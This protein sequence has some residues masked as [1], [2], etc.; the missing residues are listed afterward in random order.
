M[1]QV[2]LRVNEFQT[3]LF[4]NKIKQKYRVIALDCGTAG[5]VQYAII[6]NTVYYEDFFHT[7]DIDIVKR[8]VSLDN[9]EL[10]AEVYQKM[11][12][13]NQYYA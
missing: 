1:T 7:K 11:S 8:Y 13:M 2:H 9:D 6:N 4:T 3:L 12:L 5:F 10:H